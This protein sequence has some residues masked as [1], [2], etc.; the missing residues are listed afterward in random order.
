[1]RYHREDLVLIWPQVHTLFYATFPD[2][3]RLSV[4]CITS[5]YYRDNV[6][7]KLDANGEAVR[8]KNGKVVMIKAKVRDRATAEGK[9]KP[10]KF[11]DKHPEFAL[12][13]DWVKPE[14]KARAMRIL[15]GLKE[16]M[17]DGEMSGKFCLLTMLHW[18]LLTW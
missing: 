5:R 3:E 18:T 1:M 2:T 12:G 10:Y 17:A 13:Y 16:P 11:V 7:P 9:A 4:P 6:V 15:Q 14:D 8:D